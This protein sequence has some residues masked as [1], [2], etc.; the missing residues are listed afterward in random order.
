[1]PATRSKTALEDFRVL[2]VE[3]DPDGR[4]LLIT[5]LSN[6]GATVRGV[7]SAA[8]ALDALPTFRPQL[9]VS[10]IGM[11]DE[12]GYALMR[13]IRA[14]SVM[15]GGRIPAVAFSA[16]TSAE[17]RARALASG[18]DEHVAKPLRPARLIEALVE[19]AASMSLRP[20]ASR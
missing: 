18:F 7:A 11:P 20:C 4:E 2:V 13:R 12:D 17:H 10:D 14:L 6:Q 19:L 16:F 9:L 3:D 15:E 8:A 5:I 1:M